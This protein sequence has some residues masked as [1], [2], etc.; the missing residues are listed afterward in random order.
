MSL[1]TD[2]FVESGPRV[3]R[4]VAHHD[5]SR[6]MEEIALWASQILPEPGLRRNR[7]VVGEL[8]WRE[9]QE[10]DV[11]NPLLLL[12]PDEAQ[13][14]MDSLWECGVRPRS[15]TSAG[16]L[17]QAEKHLAD[18]RVI[19]FHNLRILPAFVDDIGGKARR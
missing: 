17:A 8:T 6:S 19:A 3:T 5:P 11:R 15:N 1:I 4:V 10:G 14:L 9:V 2:N 12:K 13:R 16:Q 18:L 7:V